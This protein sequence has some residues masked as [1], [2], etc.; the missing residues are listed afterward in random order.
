MPQT[1]PGP[2]LVLSL[3]GQKVR[4]R[5]GG[6]RVDMSMTVHPKHCRATPD[7]NIGRDN[8]RP[9]DSGEEP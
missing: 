1:D 3:E 9:T 4:E 7:M 8:D 5:L 2:R 6:M